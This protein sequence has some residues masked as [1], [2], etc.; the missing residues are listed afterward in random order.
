MDNVKKELGINSNIL[1]I[2]AIV[3]MLIDHFAYYF[4][5]A[6]SNDTYYILRILGRIAM[7]IFVY[8][9]IQGYFHT[10]NIWRYIFNIFTLATVTQISLI[11]IGNINYNY[12]QDYSVGINNYLNILYSFVFSLLIIYLLDNKVIFKAAGKIL[13]YIIKVLGI[14][15]I[16]GIYFCVRIDYEYRVPFMAA[17]IYLIEKIYKKYETKVNENYVFYKIIYMIYL[18]VLFYI[19]L[20]MQDTVLWFNISSFASIIPIMLYNRKRGKNNI[21]IKYSFYAVFLLQHIVFYLLG[22]IMMK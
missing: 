19:S 2:I 14:A 10:R 4:K 15:V 6:I 21:M 1:K 11:I 22:M 13:N 16:I 18:I 9:I 7:P 12:F 20:Y 3:F 8:L 5:Y 17:S